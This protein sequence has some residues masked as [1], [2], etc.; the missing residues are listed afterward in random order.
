MTS[1][2]Q[3]SLRGASPAD[4]RAIA[5]VQV[6]TWIMPSVVLDCLRDK[7]SAQP[8]SAQS[9]SLKEVEQRVGW[10]VSTGCRL[11][12]CGACEGAFLQGEIGM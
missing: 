2:V 8:A 12:W 1:Q 9:E 10:P 6:H 4:A 7:G 5:E 3:S 11:E